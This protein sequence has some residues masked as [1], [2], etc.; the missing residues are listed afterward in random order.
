MNIIRI[1]IFISI[2]ILYIPYKYILTIENN[3][4]C[5]NIKKQINII[6]SS[7]LIIVLSKFILF[8]LSLCILK[9]IPKILLLIYIIFFINYLIYTFIFI[10]IK[11]KKC[12][13]DKYLTNTIIGKQNLRQFSY[14]FYL[15]LLILVCY[16]L[17]LM[18]IFCIYKNK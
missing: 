4:I 10:K 5:K 2:F 17:I 15:L 12:K 11:I 18:L 8:L 6:K 16:L 1:L 7:I 9:K 13:C 3:C 14:I